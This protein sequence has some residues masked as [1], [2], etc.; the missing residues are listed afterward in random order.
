MYYRQAELP[1]CPVTATGTSVTPK[2]AHPSRGARS[3]PRLSGDL[4]HFTLKISIPETLKD[5]GG[6]FRAFSHLHHVVLVNQS[7]ASPCLMLL[8]LLHTSYIILFTKPETLL[9]GC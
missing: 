7:E 6:T 2:T 8:P 3:Y 4:P 5:L 1:A 9:S